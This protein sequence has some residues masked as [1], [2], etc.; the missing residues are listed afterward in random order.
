[1][2]V[3]GTSIIGNLIFHVKEQFGKIESHVHGFWDIHLGNKH[4]KK[5]STCRISKKHVCILKKSTCGK[6]VI[7]PH[8]ENIQKPHKI[9]KIS[10]K[11]TLWKFGIF[12]S[13][14]LQTIA[15]IKTTDKF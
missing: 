12:S 3:F 14:Q 5:I 13:A 7:F 11:N 1:L 10:I 8:V 15:V 2:W 4:G 9:Y 6:K